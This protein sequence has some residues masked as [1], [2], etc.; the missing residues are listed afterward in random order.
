MILGACTIGAL[1]ACAAT[2]INAAPTGG[3]SPLRNTTT[4]PTP[5]R[6]EFSMVQY[7]GG[8][9]LYGGCNIAFD[10]FYNDLW[11]ADF[12]VDKPDQYIWQE[13]K[14]TGV[15]PLPSCGHGTAVV[16][17][18]MYVF[19]GLTAGSKGNELHALDLRTKIW[20]RVGAKTNPVLAQRSL[21]QHS[22]V[23]LPQENGILV[24][25]GTTAEKDDDSAYQYN[26]VDASWS[27]V[28]RGFGGLESVGGSSAI[29]INDTLLVLGGF[30]N[31]TAS[32]SFMYL[33]KSNHQFIEITPHPS[34]ESD[35][36]GPIAF[37][38]AIAVNNEF[39][40]VYG[41]FSM[42][43]INP[44]VWLYIWDRF[45]ESG[46]WC[47]AT[48]SEQAT[49]PPHFAGGFVAIEQ[50]LFAFGGRIH[51]R[52]HG[53]ELSFDMWK[54]SNILKDYELCRRKTMLQ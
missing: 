33:S 37:Q 49:P 41:G 54:Y 4:T 47:R 36:L 38:G 16:G 28:S 48:S 42:A 3:G 30:V 19:G 9:L 5:A 12:Y 43:E 8:I 25:S 26:S 52:G 20:R 39:M 21:I 50:D 53:E 51:P 2:Q 46:F 45:P 31:N 44:Y 13:V 1:V 17:D 32:D 40:V 24:A 23:P 27:K 7:E 10:V 15:L 11:K 18:E 14:T 22:M 35:R 34:V 29:F 6:G